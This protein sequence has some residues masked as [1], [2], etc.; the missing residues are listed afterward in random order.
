M[1]LT[2]FSMLAPC[3]RNVG[4]SIWAEFLGMIKFIIFVKSLSNLSRGLEN[5]KRSLYETIIKIRGLKLVIGQTTFKL[6]VHK[7]LCLIFSRAHTLDVFGMQN[8]PRCINGK[9]HGT[10]SRTNG[11][12]S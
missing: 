12:L 3:I 1:I 6:Y 11:D 2:D 10:F 7:C 4:Y 9:L 5:G 8:N